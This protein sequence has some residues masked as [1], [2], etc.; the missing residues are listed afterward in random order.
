MSEG[1]RK[2]TTSMSEESKKRHRPDSPSI[3]PPQGH[4]DVSYLHK[5]I[6]LLESTKAM[7]PTGTPFYMELREP[8]SKTTSSEGGSMRTSHVL[9]RISQY[10]HNEV[11]TVREE[12]ARVEKYPDL[13]IRPI[14][15]MV[16]EKTHSVHL[17][18]NRDIKDY[19]LFSFMWD[20]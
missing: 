1:K 18:F 20:R 15:S 13:F 10:H 11:D 4:V 6:S 2:I 8:D 5:V 17:Q 9:G 3:T 19:P 14:N 16:D 7:D 12:L